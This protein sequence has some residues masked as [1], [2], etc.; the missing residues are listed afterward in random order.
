MDIES[1][2]DNG[3][4]ATYTSI[5][6]ESEVSTGKKVDGDGGSQFLQYLSYGN[7]VVLVAVLVLSIVTAVRVFAPSENKRCQDIVGTWNLPD[8]SNYFALKV[9]PAGHTQYLEALTMKLEI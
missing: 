9:Y 6:I 2:I 4:S 3:P 5:E 8:G 7:T 1:E